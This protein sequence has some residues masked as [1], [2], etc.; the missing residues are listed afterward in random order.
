MVQCASQYQAYSVLLDV[1]LGPT[2]R[3]AAL[4]RKTTRQFVE[5]FPVLEQNL[6]PQVAVQYIPRFM[7]ATQLAMTYYWDTA[8]DL[9]ADTPM[10]NLRAIVDRIMERTVA[11]LPNLPDAYLRSVGE[12]RRPGALPP[13]GLPVPPP[14]QD[15][16]G[17]GTGGAPA[18]PDRNP[19]PDQ[20][21]VERFLA[22]T[23]LDPNNTLST[24]SQQGGRRPRS[25]EGS[26]ELCLHYH[27]RGECNTLC[28]RGPNRAGAN[29]THRSLTD[30]E[31]AGLV[32]FLD[33]NNVP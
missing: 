20:T 19:H 2:H 6:S 11:Q 13:R 31:K 3:V 18:V 26:T 30:T 14:D 1:L 8:F 22:W 5:S 4:F 9:G 33:S 25:A 29:H 10:P 32:R 28:R 17:G 16:A 7:R 23:R 21:I 12:G 15:R 27:L 24:L